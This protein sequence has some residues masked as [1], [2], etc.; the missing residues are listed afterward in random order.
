MEQLE[1]TQSSEETDKALYSKLKRNV[2]KGLK[3][4]DNFLGFFPIQRVVIPYLLQ[5]LEGREDSIYS[6]DICISVPTGEGKTLC[7]VIPIANYLYTRSY[8]TLTALIIVPTRELA[9]QVGQV[10]ALFTK[11]TRD[12]LPIKTLILTGQQPFNNETKQLKS[13]R[14]DI[15]VTT[16]GRL[17]E[18]YHHLLNETPRNND[19]QKI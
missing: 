16:P 2:R 4:L 7:Y 11:S 14:P 19:A 1:S 12:K 8:P 5:G 10:F 17:S 15:L 6:S 13:I 9:N 3:G 18:H